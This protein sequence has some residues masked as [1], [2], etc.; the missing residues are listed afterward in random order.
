MDGIGDSAY[1]TAVGGGS[2][3]VLSGNSKVSIS[4]MIGDNIEEDIENAKLITRLMP[5]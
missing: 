2:L 3:V 4:P 5:L 1:W